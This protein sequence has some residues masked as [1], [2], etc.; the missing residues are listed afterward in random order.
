MNYKSEILYI[1]GDEVLESWLQ[2]IPEVFYKDGKPYGLVGS[3][4]GRDGCLYVAATVTD[5]DSPFT[6]GMIREIIRLYKNNEICLITDVESKQDLIRRS[7]DRYE[8]SY[9]VKDGILY[10]RSKNV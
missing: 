2:I 10:S 7:L 3:T 6:I 8:F 5:V 9:E 4:R 1:V